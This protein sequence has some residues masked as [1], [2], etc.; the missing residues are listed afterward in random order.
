MLEKAFGNEY[1]ANTVPWQ[2][3]QALQ[4]FSEAYP[5]LMAQLQKAMVPAAQAELGAARAVT[6]GYNDLAVGELT[7]LA[8]QIGQ[9]Q[10]AMDAGQAAADV[11]NLQRFGPSA[12][13]ALR[14]TDA[15]ANK[16]YYDNLGLAGSKMTDALNAL[17]PT[18]SAGQ[19]A[20][21]E[22]GNARMPGSDASAV[23]L[24]EKALNFGTAGRQQANNFAAA[25]NSLAGNIGALRTGL[26]PAS[27]ALGRD[28]RSSPALAALNPVTKPGDAPY[29]V[30]GSV[31]NGLLNAAG[32]N[33][34]IRAGKF[35]S[36]GDA[37]EQDSRAFSN[38]ASGASGAAKI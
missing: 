36:W 24:A 33:E 31:W 32:A 2:A 5:Q 11:A 25:V 35:K 12:G 9:V 6:P 29:Q 27:L 19:R 10:G 38:I 17:S 26:A 8:P 14:A 23:N 7:R 18:L 37:V 21:I 30:G 4:G 16:E 3:Q 13:A 1:E 34:Q 22:R 28:S 20:E 15:S